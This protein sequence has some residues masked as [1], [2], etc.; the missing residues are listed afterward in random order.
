MKSKNISP[1]RIPHAHDAFFKMAM[2][3]KRVAQEFFEAHLPRDF[4]PFIDFDKLELTSE[5]YIDDLR[6]A[7]SADMLFKA[8]VY[9]SEAYFYLLVD[10]QSRP[11]KMMP[12]RMLKYSCNIIDQ[13]LKETGSQSI[14]FVLPFVLYHGEQTWSYSTD[15]RDL[16]DAPKVLIED[17][18]LK[19]FFLIDLNKIEDRVIKERAWLGV[20]EL[21]LKHIFDRDIGPTINAIF[22]LLKKLKPLDSA[23]FTEAV[24]LYILDRGK[25][26]DK[27]AFIKGVRFELSE[28]LGEKMGTIVEDFWSEGWREGKQQGKQEGKREGKR[29]GKQESMEEVA[30]RLLLK[31]E[32]REFIAEITGLTLARIQE[33]KEKLFSVDC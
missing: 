33:I 30:K 2:T 17:Y 31:H 10:H 7:S 28:E 32:N 14:P 12:F 18:F 8:E 27:H 1:K 5:T 20:M 9:G 11:D 3:D 23:A 15:I 19:P 22:S 13:H 6:Q 24:L 21:T 29:E 4:L 26:S 16:V 25:V